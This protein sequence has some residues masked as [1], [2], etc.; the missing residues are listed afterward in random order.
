MRRSAPYAFV[1]ALVLAAAGSHLQAQTSPPN[2][3]PLWQVGVHVERLFASPLGDLINEVIKKEAPDAEANVATFVEALGMD[4][5][6]AIKEVV[7]FGDAFEPDAA[8]AVANI[9]PTRGNVE[10]WL[11]AAPGYQ[12]E[13]IANDTIVHSFVM[14]EH[15]PDARLW[16]AIPLS[17]STDTYILV[18]SFDRDVTVALVDQVINRGMEDLGKPLAGDAML[19]VAVDELSR[20][21]IEIDENEPGSAII[22]TIQSIVISAASENDELVATCEI[23]TDDPARA[24]Q[25]H[26]LIMGMKAMVQLAIPEKD[27]DAQK[28]ARLLGG[29]NV[30]YEQGATTLS[31]RFAMD[32]AEIEKLVKEKHNIK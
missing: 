29:L 23:D 22:K 14:E 12:S 5:R 25:L 3:E 13:T 2:G 17:K 28:F 6:T 26:Q 10:G 18:A 8:R 1:A 32:Y 30:E 19:A 31:T 11:L 27:P 15:G 21:P 7:I 20:A 4:P 24:Q 16:C 9:G